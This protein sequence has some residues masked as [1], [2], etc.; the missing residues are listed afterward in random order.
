MACLRE[1][2]LCPP[3]AHPPSNLGCWSQLFDVK[4]RREGPK[5]DGHSRLARTETAG[6]WVLMVDPLNPD[7]PEGVESTVARA[8]TR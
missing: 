7:E 4:V 2:E 1:R 8:K 5:A 3:L 6:G